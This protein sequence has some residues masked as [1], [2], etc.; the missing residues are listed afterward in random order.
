MPKKGTDDL[1]RL[2]RSLSAT[3]KAYFRK[4]A[5]RH[6][7]GEK[8]HYL[9]LFAA[10]EKQKVYDEKKLLRDEKYI[11]ELPYLKNY[12]S[13]IILR[14]MQAYRIDET[15]EN[16]IHRVIGQVE[17]LFSKGLYD[18][19]EKQIRKGK[20]LCEQHENNIY[21]IKLLYFEGSIRMR[22]SSIIRETKPGAIDHEILDLLEAEK[23]IIL[24]LD[25]QRRLFALMH[26]KGYSKNSSERKKFDTIMS[27]PLLADEKKAIGFNSR[28]IF[29]NIWASYSSFIYD[30][31]N[32]YTYC[33]KHLALR[34]AE[35]RRLGNADKYIKSLSNFYVACF[36]LKRYGECE[37]LLQEM[38]RLPIKSKDDE[39]MVYSRYLHNALNLYL[40]EADFAKGER[41]AETEWPR[42]E[43]LKERMDPRYKINILFKTVHFS[44]ITGNYK[45]SILLINELLTDDLK[46]I[47]PSL[48]MH[49]LV[50]KVLLHY[51]MGHDDVLPHQVRAL[52]RHA[53]KAGTGNIF[54]YIIINCFNDMILKNIPEE[55]TMRTAAEKLGTAFGDPVYRENIFHSFDYLSWIESKIN[56]R[57]FAGILREKALAG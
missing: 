31:P 28:S 45:K 35:F 44:F 2:I 10:I 17:F 20:K 21:K 39:I 32:L 41:L 1:F 50:L 3:E 7:I 14:A 49:T 48:Y 52:Q 18:L 54:E 13:D 46:K 6:V 5:E 40:A 37:K 19:C 15:V 9:K 29:Y 33:K 43:A 8:N 16:K 42:F 57:S 26:E 47:M 25:L 36:N 56:G 24:Y 4:F 55:K 34:R 38:R 27:D 22:D 12:L 51:E 11:R 30:Y 53:G 23:N